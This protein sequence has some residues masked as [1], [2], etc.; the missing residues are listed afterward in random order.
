M[1]FLLSV[2]NL[3]VGLVNIVNL[4]CKE[5]EECIIL[6]LEI[7]YLQMGVCLCCRQDWCWCSIVLDFLV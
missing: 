7:A 1:F 2:I 6:M 3:I 5:L 4:G